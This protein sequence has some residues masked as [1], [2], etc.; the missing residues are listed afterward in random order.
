MVACWSNYDTVFGT[1]NHYVPVKLKVVWSPGC[2]DAYR[3]IHSINILML[4][5]YNVQCTLYWA[6]SAGPWYMECWSQHWESGSLNRWNRSRPFGELY[7]GAVWHMWL[8]G[9]H[10]VLCCATTQWIFVIQHGWVDEIS[11]PIAHYQSLIVQIINVFNVCLF[12]WN[13]SWVCINVIVFHCVQDWWN[14]WSFLPRSCP[15][16]C[17]RSGW[18]TGTHRAVRTPKQTGELA[19]VRG[20]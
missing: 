6:A 20:E 12:S 2:Q 14:G 10:H 13:K 17:C 1:C 16:L 18:W 7:C 3:C 8:H 5:S 11:S 15:S 19:S 4:F 9:V